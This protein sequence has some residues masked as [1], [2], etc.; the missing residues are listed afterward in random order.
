M[1]CIVALAFYPQL[2]LERTAPTVQ[3]TVAGVTGGQAPEAQLA[4]K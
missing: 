2:I 3:H 1:L 4:R